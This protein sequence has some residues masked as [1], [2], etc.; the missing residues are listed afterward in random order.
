MKPSTAS[1]AAFFAVSFLAGS[2]LAQPKAWTP[3]QMMQVKRV[4]GVQVSPDGKRVVYAVRQALL[5]DGKSEYASHLWVAD[6]PGGGGGGKG[7]GGGSDGGKQLTDGDD[8]HWSPDGKWIAFG[9]TR[10]GKRNLWLVPASG[11]EPVQLTHLKAAVTSFKWAPDSKSIA[12]TATDGPTPDEEKEKNDARVVGEN[13]KMSRLYVVS[14]AT[15][16]KQTPRLLTKGD[17]NVAASGRGGYDWSPDCKTIVFT[18]TKTPH[19]DDWTSADLELVNV[20]DGGGSLNLPAGPVRYA[21]HFSPDGKEI[22]FVQSDRTW[23]GSGAIHVHPIRNKISMPLAQTFDGFGRYSEIVGWAADGKSIYFT[24]MHGTATHIGR[25]PLEGPPEIIA[26]TDAVATGIHLNATRTHFGFTLELLNIAAPE[27]YISPVDTYK[28]KRVSLVNANL[29]RR[30]L[31]G[32]TQVI[33]WKSKDG[34]EIEGLLTY[35]RGYEKGKLYPLLVNVHGGPMGVFTQTYVGNPGPY[36]IAAFS[37]RGY[38]V[39][40]PNPRG[41][42]GY[43]KKFRYA[44]YNDWGGGDYQDLMTGVDHVIKMGV[45]DE[46]RLGIM[47]W[48]YGGFMTSWAITQTKRFKAASVGAGVTNLMSFTGTADI[49][50]FLPDYFGGEFWD[51][52]ETYRR[53]SAMFN[54]KGVTTPTL[55]QHGERDER[56]PLSQGLELYNALKRQ[57]CTTKMVIY[58]RTPHGIEEPRLLVDCMERNLEWFGKHLGK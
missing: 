50:S 20:E 4:S 42:S 58:P 41:S 35:P 44:N 22:A 32:N 34:L 6:A 30:A 33:R 2:A 52:P 17:F 57:G 21:P 27:A 18:R 37:S 25:L 56:V 46:N 9:S 10:A 16:E 53:H 11:G 28:P 5:D 51:N 38:A 14:A 36:P 48:S 26:K 39:L 49:P 3:L 43:G 47:G 1:L 54:I 45:A 31:I 29:P 12:F 55:I 7:G 24:E 19:A 23:A 40:R 8:P 15:K 13:I